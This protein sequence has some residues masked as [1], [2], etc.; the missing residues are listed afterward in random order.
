MEFD[1][2]KPFDDYIPTGESLTPEFQKYM[3]KTC[4]YTWTL[5]LA[6]GKYYLVY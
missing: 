2:I 1:K 3:T 6:V 5:Y 4:G